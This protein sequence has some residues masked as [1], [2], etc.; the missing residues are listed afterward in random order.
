MIKKAKIVLAN[1]EFSDEEIAKVKAMRKEFTDIGFAG[2]EKDDDLY[3]RFN[4][5]IKKYFEEMKFYK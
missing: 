5:V 3:N 1:S 4:E 2:K